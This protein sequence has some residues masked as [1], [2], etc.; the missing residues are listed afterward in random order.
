MSRSNYTEDEDEPGQFAMWRGQVASAMRGKRGQAFLRDM[1]AALDAMPEKRLI[2]NSLQ[3]PGG[4]VCAIG[5]L[6]VKRGIDMTAIDP[7]EPHQV[8]RVFNIAN[9]MASEIA[10]MNDEYFDFTY[11]GNER[12]DY[13]PEERWQKMRDW[14][15]S[16]VSP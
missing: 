13:T 9:Q 12:R 10:Y 15:A 2:Q 1:L 3:E 11:V 14:V 5:A 6:G 8:A 4:E 16:K 7:E